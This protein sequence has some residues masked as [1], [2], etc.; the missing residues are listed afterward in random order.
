M[1][2]SIYILP[3]AEKDCNRLSKGIYNRCKKSILKLESKP[4]PVGCKRLVGEDGYRIRV[5]DYRILYRVDD[6][7]KRIF[8]YRIKHR[9]EVYR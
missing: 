7:L 1:K 4:R 3:T 6:Q 9:R 8:I 5:G 2:Y